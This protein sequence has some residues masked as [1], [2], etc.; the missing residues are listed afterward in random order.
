[1]KFLFDF[2]PVILFF[3][4]FKWGEGH[5]DTAQALIAQY[6]GGLVSGGT[7][8]ADQAPIMLATIIMIIVSVGQIAYLLI[9]RKKIHAPIWLSLAIIGVFGSATIYF[10][11]DSFI[12]WKPTVLYWCFALGIFI[13]Q[14]FLHKNLIRSM[15]GEAMTLPD[16]IWQRVGLSWSAFFATMGLLNLYVAFSGHFSRGDW[17]NFKVFGG[18]GLMFVFAIA[19][20]MYLSKYTQET[21]DKAEKET[22]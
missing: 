20:A 3:G 13:S 1:M 15:M 19:Q 22:S 6:A 10:H 2:F 12:K 14:T 18:F 8:T 9:R 5:A 4:I 16:A 17:V 21:E 11:N 7:V